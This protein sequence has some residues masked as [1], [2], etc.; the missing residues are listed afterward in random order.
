[1]FE[2]ESVIVL[3]PLKAPN[4]AVVLKGQLLTR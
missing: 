3:D 4:P 1:M 2:I